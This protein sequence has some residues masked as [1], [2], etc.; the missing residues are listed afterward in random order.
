MNKR[1]WSAVSG[2]AVGALVVTGL[3]APMQA[4]ATPAAPAP[5]SGDPAA[6]QASRPDNLPNPLAEAAGRRDARLPSPS[7]SRARRPRR[8]STATASSRSRPPAKNGKAG[9]SK[10]VNY[11]V[12]REEDIFTILTDFGTRSTPTHGRHRRAAAQPDPAARP[13]L[14]RQRD[15]RQLDLLGAGLQPHPLSWT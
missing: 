12:N 6:A 8:R 1:H 2:L 4:Q 5:V 7:C 3:T 15:R 9:K 11:P 14:G 13:H 10:Y